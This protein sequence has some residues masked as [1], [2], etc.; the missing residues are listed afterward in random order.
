M[1]LARLSAAI[2]DIVGDRRG[3]SRRVRR[4]AGAPNAQLP[5][6]ANL[7]WRSPEMP[8]DGARDREH[9]AR[10]VRHGAAPNG[11]VFAC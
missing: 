11:S 7:P 6:E 3:G 9:P 2:A 4:L 1:S 8:L 5:V 10:L